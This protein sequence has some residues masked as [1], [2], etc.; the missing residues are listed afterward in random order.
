MCL[1]ISIFSPSLL[2]SSPCYLVKLLVTDK[3]D[4]NETD[5][6]IVQSATISV[7]TTPI[8]IIHSE[9]DNEINDIANDN[10]TCTNVIAEKRTLN[11]ME[12]MLY[13][14]PI[15]KFEWIIECLQQ[16][17][18][19]I[20]TSIMYIRTLPTKTILLNENNNSNNDSNITNDNMITNYGVSYVAAIFNQITNKYKPLYD[21]SIYLCGYSGQ[22]LNE[23]SSL[24]NN[25]G[26]KEVITK[27]LVLI[28]RIKKAMLSG[29]QQQQQ[30]KS[31][32]NENQINQQQRFILL[33]N[34]TN[35]IITSDLV[36]F[37][38]KLFNKRQNNNTTNNYIRISIVNSN[39]LFDSISCGKGIIDNNII[40]TKNYK[41]IHNK[42]LE[43]FNIINK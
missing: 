3:L 31:D 12:A 28:E 16:E 4:P 42:A 36:H 22:K 21:H 26:A 24:L 7:T 9:N 40:M 14:I 13:G 10:I 30:P 39:W 25:A 41:P 1:N 23:I 15:I 5:L 38:T 2:F 32:N 29:I 33:C 34:D 18:I 17:K 11:L 37:I 35:V 19:I 43:L 8:T 6:C 20:P 27:S